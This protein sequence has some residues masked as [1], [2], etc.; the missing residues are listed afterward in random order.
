MLG[1]RTFSFIIL[2]V[3]IALVRCSPK[4]KKGDRKDKTHLCL[5]CRTPAHGGARGKCRC[6]S[7]TSNTSILQDSTSEVTTVS[8]PRRYLMKDFNSLSRG[9]FLDAMSD[10]IT[11]ITSIVPDWTLEPRDSKNSSALS[12]IIRNLKGATE[13]SRIEKKPLRRGETLRDLLKGT[14]RSK[15]P[16]GIASRLAEV[17]KYKATSGTG[18]CGSEFSGSLLKLGEVSQLPVCSS[19]NRLNFP[20]LPAITSSASPDLISITEEASR[21]DCSGGNAS[22]SDSSEEELKYS[23]LGVTFARLNLN[24]VFARQPRSLFGEIGDI[25]VKSRNSPCKTTNNVSNAFDLQQREDFLE[26]CPL[27]NSSLSSRVS[28]TILMN[29]GSDRNSSNFSVY[30]SSNEPAA[31]LSNS[32]TSLPVSESAASLLTSETPSSGRTSESS[33]HESSSDSESKEEVL[34]D[35]CD[36]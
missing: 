15:Y 29:I 12:H 18:S 9:T 23:S 6:Q 13:S 32:P 33:I 17:R 27:P 3:L 16:S 2:L 19:F 28:S 21:E 8:V 25:D 7:H 1:Y 31:S 30:E 14:S 11:G 24:K 10:P 26:Q 4:N 35:N 20:R 22:V 36:F 34:N 5:P